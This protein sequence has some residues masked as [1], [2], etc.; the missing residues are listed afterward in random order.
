MIDTH[1]VR[2]YIHESFRQ[3]LLFRLHIASYVHDAVDYEPGK[4]F[5][6]GSHGRPRRPC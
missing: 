4:E 2:M 3:F 6:S 5:R 1:E